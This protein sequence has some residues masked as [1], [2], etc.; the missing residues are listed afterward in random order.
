[1]PATLFLIGKRPAGRWIWQLNAAVSVLIF[2]KDSAT[3]IVYLEDTG[4][5][6]SVFPH[7]G[8]PQSASCKLLGPNGHHIPSWGQIQPKL[9]FGA[10]VFSCVFWRATVSRPILGVDFLSKHKLLVDAAGRRVVQMASLRP[11]S[12]PFCL[13]QRHQLSSCRH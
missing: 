12:P 11:L 8:P 13:P 4:A 1:M 6:V 2:V 7:R 3:S 5:A 9:T 10:M